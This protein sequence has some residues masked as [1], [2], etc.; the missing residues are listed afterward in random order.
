[1]PPISRITGKPPISER[2]M[3]LSQ[4]PPS[5]ET[6]I[7]ASKLNK[8]HSIKR[9]IDG[10]ISV[11]SRDMDKNTPIML[12]AGSATR[13]YKPVVLNYLA[14]K[15]A[16]VNARNTDG[17]TAMHFAGR[18]GHV[19][20]VLK[21]AE[22]KAKVNVKNIQG[23]TP[24]HCAVRAGYPDVV[25]EMIKL[26]ADVNAADQGG[27]TVL[28]AAIT[29][30]YDDYKEN[31]VELLLQ[32]DVDIDPRN[33]SGKSARDYASELGYVSISSLFTGAVNLRLEDWDEL[34]WISER[35]DDELNRRNR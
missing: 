27:M 35:S 12:V 28:M 23:E 14:K 5:V 4:R 31:I 15:G 13:D 24:L 3:P 2:P 30:K 8:P 18:S 21:L 10:G 20:A 22:W 29:A 17:D 25:A 6:L 11:D 34:F 19:E 26:G 16:D 7:E 33:L 9:C 1:M 32:A